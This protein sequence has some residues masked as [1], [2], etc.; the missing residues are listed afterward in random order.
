MKPSINIS[1]VQSYT[2]PTTNKGL[3][4]VEPYLFCIIPIKLFDYAAS[5]ATA[6]DKPH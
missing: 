4:K 3:I 1:V 6:A 5:N 2:D